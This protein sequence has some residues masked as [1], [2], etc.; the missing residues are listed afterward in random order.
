MELA[1]ERTGTKNLSFLEG[2]LSLTIKTEGGG[3]ESRCRLEGNIVMSIFSI[4]LSGNH[5]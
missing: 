1:S 5:S 2:N 4:C 3:L